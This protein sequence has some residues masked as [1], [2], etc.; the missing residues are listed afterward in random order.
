MEE[1]VCVRST[2]TRCWERGKAVIAEYSIE[3]VI[4]EYS[5]KGGEISEIEFDI[6][7]ESR[8]LL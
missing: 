3:V 4:F 5:V 8:V 1:E 2:H 6:N 7:A